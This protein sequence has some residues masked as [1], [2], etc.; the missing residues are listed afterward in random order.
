[1]SQ[2]EF[3]QQ[4]QAG[5]NA[6]KRGQYRSSVAYLEQATQLVPLNT[7][8]GGEVQLWLVS[9]YEGMGQVKE[10]IALCRQLTRHPSLEVRKQSKQL[11]YI[12]EAPR[13][14][15]PEEWVVKIPDLSKT[16]ESNSKFQ[17]GTG[18]PTPQKSPQQPVIEPLELEA[19]QR[20]GNNFLILALLVV[21]CALGGWIWLT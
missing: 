5:Q 21:L 15:R 11:L 20:K 1:M 16:S 12:L 6:F 3:Q 19:H 8:L 4:Y 17:Q 13:L 10:A 2:E 18:R 9:A 7:R 14:K